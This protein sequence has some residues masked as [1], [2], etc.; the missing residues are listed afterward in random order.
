MHDLHT[1][2][3]LLKMNDIENKYRDLEGYLYSLTIENMRVINRRNSSPAKFFR[4]NPFTVENIK[5]YLSTRCPSVKVVS[6]IFVTATSKHE[7]QCSIHGKFLKSWN[8][9]KNGQYCPDCGILIRSDKK[10]NSIEDV[11]EAFLQRGYFLISETYQANDIPLTYVCNKHTDKGEQSLTWGNFIN[12]KGCRFCGRENMIQKQTKPQET[13]EAELFNVFG[14]KYILKSK[15]TKTNGKVE[16]YCRDCDAHFS[17]KAAHLLDGHMGCRCKSNS[18]GED[19]ITQFLKDNNISFI[20][21]YRL[22]QCRNKKPLPFDFAVFS[23]REKSNLLCLIEFQGKQHY[24]DE[25]GWSSD[26]EKNKAYFLKQQENDQIKRN[27]CQLNS[28]SLIEIPYW[29]MSKIDD[30]LGNLLITP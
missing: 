22:T 17:S 20:G 13:F 15:Y 28:I 24:S 3:G 5:L 6:D 2:L 12:G 7:F 11:R 21:Q 19:I 10:R 14:D 9:V 1:K 29:K 4:N 23:D 26:L 8:E 25:F 16:I 30:I 18:H 27:Y